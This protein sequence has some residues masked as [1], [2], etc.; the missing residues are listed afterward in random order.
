MP[1]V[2]EVVRKSPLPWEAFYTAHRRLIR[3]HDQF[4]TW[5]ILIENTQERVQMCGENIY[6]LDCIIKP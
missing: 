5:T 4:G 6:T 2:S 3:L 1:S